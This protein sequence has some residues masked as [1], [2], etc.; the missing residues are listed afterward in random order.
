MQPKIVQT[1]SALTEITAHKVLL[2]K[3]YYSQVMITFKKVIGLG[4]NPEQ[5]RGRIRIRNKTFQI[6]NSYCILPLA[7]QCCLAHDFHVSALLQTGNN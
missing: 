2:Q 1:F 4:P 3:K 6:R 7:S 5:L